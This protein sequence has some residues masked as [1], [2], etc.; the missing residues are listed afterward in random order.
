LI[1]RDGELEVLEG[2][3][4]LAACRWL[5]QHVDPIAWANVKC[6]VL[7]ADTDEKLIFALLGQYHIKGKK[8]W[9]PFEKAGFLYRR[10]TQHKDDIATVASELSIGTKEARH[11]IDVYQFMIDQGETE[12]DRWS[13]Y[14]EYLKSRAIKKARE[15]Y[16]DFDKIIVGKIQGGEIRRAVDVRDNLPTICSGPVKNLKRFVE[17]KVDF[18]EAHV[19]AVDA[20]GENPD[21]RRIYKFR[22]W[23]ASAE[24]EEDLV[25]APTNIRDKLEYELSHIEKRVKRLKARLA[26]K[27]DDPGATTTKASQPPN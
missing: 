1:V 22:Q 6:T 9:V 26:Q 23:L 24:T 8:D 3:S 14:D 15:H 11:L 2:N 21:Y 12:R 18:E 20:G 27:S 10:F 5:Y 25:S 7:P 19:V 4:R 13:Y 16:P 17:G